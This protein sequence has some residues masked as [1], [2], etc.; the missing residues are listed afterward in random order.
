MRGITFLA[1]VFCLSLYQGFYLCAQSEPL[2]HA[3]QQGLTEQEGWNR[4]RPELPDFRKEIPKPDLPPMPP[5]QRENKTGPDLSEIMVNRFNFV[6]NTVFSTDELLALA[7]PFMNRKIS[8]EDLQTLRL[9]ITRHYTDSGFINSGAILP[10]QEVIDGVVTFR[11]IEGRLT[12]IE[13]SGNNRLREFYIRNRLA[14]GMDGPLNIHQLQESVRMLA[15]N[16]LIDRIN[17]ELGPGSQLGEA[18]LTARI[19]EKSPC[20]VGI[21]VNN[22]QSPRIGSEGAELYA[23]DRNLFGAGDTL[24]FR[25]GLTEGLKDVMGYYELPV[26]ARDTTVQIRYD[27]S[28]SEVVERPF[29]ILDIKGK[30]STIGVG[31]R[32]PIYHTSSHE[33]AIALRCELRESETFLLGHPFSFTEGVEN[34]ESRVTALRFVQEWF[35][36]KPTQVLAFRSVV[37]AGIDAFGATIHSNGP[38]G[39]FLAWLAQ[40]QWAHRFNSGQAIFRTDMQCCDESV[41][42][43]EKFSVGGESSVRGYRVN[44][45]VRDNAVVG[46]LELRFPL[47]RLPIPRISKSAEDG[48]LQLAVFS[49]WGW[50]E[51]SNDPNFG[52]RT[53]ASAG[54]GVRWDPSQNLHARFYWGIAFRDMDYGETDPRDSGIHFQI[55]WRLF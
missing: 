22:Q 10:D 39:R 55:D 36:R 25:I 11:I 37:S 31:V 49:D 54:P 15:E 16:P 32:H 33:I 45:L 20:K 48:T 51:N 23:S 12:E 52:P 7:R 53:I 4:D 42:P 40:I 34:G 13:V 44:E 3:A 19:V 27:R 47:L 24:G 1:M 6:G 29:D 21:E 46:S 8:F 50:A 30:S 18:V 2:P 26:T 17:A 41:L 28:S 38:D 43:M 35:Y 5:D 9:M 14:L